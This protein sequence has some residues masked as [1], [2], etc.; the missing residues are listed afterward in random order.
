MLIWGKHDCKFYLVAGAANDNVSSLNAFD[1]ALLKAGIGNV[2]IVKMSS[3]LPPF[4]EKIEPV[5][6]PYGALVPMAYAEIE[7]A[8]K[9]QKIVAA[10]A[11][12][13]PKDKSLPGVIMELSEFDKEERE[14][15]EK[16]RKMAEHALEY[17]GY[18]IEKIDSIS[19]SCKVE[20]DFAAAIAAVVLWRR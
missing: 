10:V 6:L 20:E 2:N 5:K 14:V 13:I 4:A 12:A 19:V 9:G 11:V 16:V 3:I 15:E 17:R 7:S 8:R 18:E 1:K